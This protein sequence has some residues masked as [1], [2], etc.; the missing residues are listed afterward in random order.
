MKRIVLLVAVMLNVLV[1]PFVSA[2]EPIDATRL[3]LVRDHCVSAQAALQRVLRGD[4]VVRINRGR[5]YEEMIKL[6]SALNSRA[7]LNTYDASRLVQ[8]AALFE[9]EFGAFKSTWISYET[10]LRETLRYKC[11]EQ[12]EAFYASLA[13]TREY[14]TQLT[15]HIGALGQLLDTYKS[16]F[17]ELRAQI[18]QPPEG[19]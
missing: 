19:Q 17:D 10:S 18:P 3:Q 7:A 16:G 15:S 9:A 12:P 6:L 1:S 5:S 14:R 8:T 2:V 13:R 11:Q 4:T